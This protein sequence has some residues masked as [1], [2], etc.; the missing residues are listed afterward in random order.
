M[1]NMVWESGNDSE[2]FR[3]SYLKKGRPPLPPTLSLMKRRITRN[4]STYKTLTS[5][6]FP[7]PMEL[8]LI[9]KVKTLKK[10]TDRID[11][12]KNNRNMNPKTLKNTKKSTQNKNYRNLNPK[13]QKKNQQNE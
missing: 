6:I 4:L 3:K 1:Q 2:W 7:P 9:L 11:V 5:K 10:S 13:I 12:P 8:V